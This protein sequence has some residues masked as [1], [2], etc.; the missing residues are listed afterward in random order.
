[1][2]CSAVPAVHREQWQLNAGL[3]ITD[4]VLELGRVKI[5]FVKMK[6]EFT[7]S[8]YMFDL[9]SMMQAFLDVNPLFDGLTSSQV[10]NNTGRYGNLHWF[11]SRCSYLISLRK[12]YYFSES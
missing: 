3:R 6:R 4:L 7:V 12:K 8:H 11:L 10:R 2:L 9:C 5:Q 1:M